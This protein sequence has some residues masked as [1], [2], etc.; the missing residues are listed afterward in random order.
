MNK[1]FAPAPS[2]DFYS[3][4]TNKPCTVVIWEKAAHGCSLHSK[5]DEGYW[6]CRLE[7]GKKPTQIITTLPFFKILFFLMTQCTVTEWFLE[8]RPH[9]DHFPLPTSPTKHHFSC[10]QMLS[11]QKFSLKISKKSKILGLSLIFI[12]FSNTRI[13]SSNAS[14]EMLSNIQVLYHRKPK[15]TTRHF[16]PC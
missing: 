7:T 2:L 1:F 5:A 6:K 4:W 9:A 12:S 13:P 3:Q 15:A 11:R 16:F 14:M 10:T 8:K